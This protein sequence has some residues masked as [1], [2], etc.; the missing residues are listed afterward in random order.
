M[1]RRIDAQTKVVGKVYVYIY[2]FGRWNMTKPG[3]DDTETDWMLNYVGDNEFSFGIA[4]RT[5]RITPIKCINNFVRL[6]RIHQYYGY[7]HREFTSVHIQNVKQ[8]FN[9]ILF[10][11]FSC[12]IGIIIFIKLDF[13]SL[14]L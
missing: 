3:L 14:I 1:S 2:L 10:I 11:F 4:L 13:Y 12:L 6:L 5:I 9:V 8:T 7:A